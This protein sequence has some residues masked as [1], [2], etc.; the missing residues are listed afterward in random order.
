MARPRWWSRSRG[1]PSAVYDAWLGSMRSEARPGHPDPGVGGGSRGTSWQSAVL[2]IGDADGTWQHVGWHEIESGGWNAE[3][4]QLSWARYGGAAVPSTHG[5]GLPELFRERIAASIVVER[6]LPVSGE[7][8]VVLNGRRDLAQAR[9]VFEWHATLGRGL[10]W[11]TPGLRE[12]VDEALAELRLEYDPGQVLD[13]SSDE[14]SARHV[15]AETRRPA[16]ASA[17]HELNPGT[18]R[19]IGGFRACVPGGQQAPVM[20]GR[21]RH[22]RVVDCSTEIP[23]P[24]STSGR[25]SPTSGSSSSGG[26]K[27]SAS[28]LAASAGSNRTSPGRRVRTA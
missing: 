26:A 19:G 11:R 14:W 15:P 13:L 28:N 22:H 16:T 20:S 7:R 1:L 12:T 24:A 21:Q 4:R 23:N 3:T 10:N 17:R 9:P 6:F 2:S 8:G 25:R 5:A 27:R 18:D